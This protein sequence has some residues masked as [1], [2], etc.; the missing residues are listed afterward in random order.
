MEHADGSINNTKNSDE[1]F[2]DHMSYV[3]RQGMG[4]L[5]WMKIDMNLPKSRAWVYDA[6]VNKA[7]SKIGNGSG[8][9]S[10]L[11]V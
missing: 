4:K 10:E 6:A 3:I 8:V 2:L 9:F 11:I 5:R 7:R 1:D